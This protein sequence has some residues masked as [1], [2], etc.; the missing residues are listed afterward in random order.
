MKTIV[1]RLQD[2]DPTLT[3]LKLVQLPEEYAAEL[4]DLLDAIRQNTTVTYVLFERHFVRSLSHDQWIQVL[5]AVGT[6]KYLEEIEVW[7]VRVP[8]QELC[9]AVQSAYNLK[10]L[11]FGFVT[12]L[13]SLKADALMGHPSLRNFYLSDF[14]LSEDTASL[15]SLLHALSTCPQM[16]Y[17]E[18]FQYQQEDPPFT[19]SGLAGL[20][21][22]KSLQHLTLRRM[23]LTADVTEAMLQS[24]AN[25]KNVKVLNL[26]ENNLGDT[27]CFA[28]G[29]A[30][31]VSDSVKEV[32][33]RK[34]QISPVGCLHL[35]QCL[36]HNSSLEKLNLACN[37][38]Q[39][40]GARALAIL[41][42]VHPSLKI[43]E[44]H[45]TQ[46]TDM[47]CRL[48]AE[49]LKANTSLLNLDVSFNDITEDTYL[50]VA[51]ALKVNQ[52]LKTINI[53]VNKKMK[54][55]ACEAILGMVKENFV[56]ESVSTLMRVRF[57]PAEYHQFED[58][59]HQINL[60]LRLNHA[61]RG[62][63]LQGEA[64]TQEWAISLLAMHDDINGLY[65]L[66]QS[67]PSLCRHMLTLN[68]DKNM[69]IP[70]FPLHNK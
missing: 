34:N 43:L 20:M 27:G 57:D 7:S 22:S 49:T 3:K 42:Q 45:R 17:I 31:S 9:E 2:N 46:L 51:E 54:I 16:E 62:R 1:E 53:Q 48:L 44:L 63:L 28:L 24:V 41:L 61:G 23:R 37:P 29:R 50:Y 52:T 21:E 15:D 25:N 12:L 36:T 32:D 19:A 55:Q 8:L 59:L 67:N 56:L 18:L 10:R 4:G 39:D 40:I 5:Q 68:V 35:T 11:G 69:A 26:K 6:M 60:Y 13:G 30:L 14:R 66:M 38:L 70:V 33:L 65:Y 47:G 64:T 58:L